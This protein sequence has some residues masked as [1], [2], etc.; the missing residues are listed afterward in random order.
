MADIGRNYSNPTWSSRV[1]T[2]RFWRLTRGTRPKNVDTTADE[3]PCSRRTRA[4]SEE[5]VHKWSLSLNLGHSEMNLSELMGTIT[6]N[7]FV[8]HFCENYVSLMNNQWCIRPHWLPDWLP[9]GI[10]VPHLLPYA[11]I[12]SILLRRMI[13]YWKNDHFN[14]IY[15]W[16]AGFWPKNMLISM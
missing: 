15:S 14:V 12:S 7:R 1:N 10:F 2:T 6:F 16:S 8:V 4:S 13:F 5:R 3:R 11:A 9:E